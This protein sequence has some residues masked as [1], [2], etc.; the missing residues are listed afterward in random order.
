MAMEC[1]KAFLVNHIWENGKI[2]KQM[3]MAFINGKM[4]IDMKD[5]G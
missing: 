1:G 4:V 2:V 5:H 3:E